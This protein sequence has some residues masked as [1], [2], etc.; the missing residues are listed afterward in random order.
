M[1]VVLGFRRGTTFRIWVGESGEALMQG[2]RVTLLF[3]VVTVAAK[4]ALSIVGQQ[5]GMSS[6][7]SG[8]TELLIPLAATLAAQNIVVYL[9]SRDQQLVAA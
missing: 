4:V 1:G 3:W 2:T 9:R 7:A 8:A 6:L 5:V